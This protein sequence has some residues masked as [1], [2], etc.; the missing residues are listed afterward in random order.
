MQVGNAGNS[1]HPKGQRYLHSSYRVNDD[2][3]HAQ[4]VDMVLCSASTSQW[5]DG[6]HKDPGIA[7]ARGCS[8]VA[9]WDCM[10][11]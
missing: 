6:L 9:A 10:V 1:V 11:A 7:G 4:P 8:T 2:W 5:E 3:L